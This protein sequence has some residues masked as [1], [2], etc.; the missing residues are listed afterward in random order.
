MDLPRKKGL[1][2]Y[3]YTTKRMFKD[4]ELDPRVT[5]DITE[6]RSRIMFGQ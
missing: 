5:E 3:K 2:P 1:N 6:K 4:K